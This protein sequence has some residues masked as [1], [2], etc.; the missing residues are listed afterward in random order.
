MKS[1]NLLT[2]HLLFVA[3]ALAGGFLGAGTAAVQLVVGVTFV[4][5]CVGGTVATLIMMRS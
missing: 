1:R 3:S 2:R 4:I 5:L